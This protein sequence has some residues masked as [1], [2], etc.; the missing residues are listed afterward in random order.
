MPSL[1]TL[2]S[3]TYPLLKPYP[4]FVTYHPHL[5]FGAQV[6]RVVLCRIG[7]PSRYRPFISWIPTH[8]YTAPHKTWRGVMLYTLRTI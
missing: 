7:T 8:F 1:P 4:T 3:P 2:P 5:P 6:G